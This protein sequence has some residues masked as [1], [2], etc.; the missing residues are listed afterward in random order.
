M[1]ENAANGVTTLSKKQLEEIGSPK[2]K[3]WA[4]QWYQMTEKQQEAAVSLGWNP[5]KWDANRWPLPKK[6]RWTDLSVK[7]QDGLRALGEAEESWN[8]W[9]LGDPTEVSRPTEIPSLVK[10][11]CDLRFWHQLSEAEHV[12]AKALGF[13]PGAWNSTEMADLDDSINRF[14]GANFEGCITQGCDDDS[15]DKALKLA[16]SHPKVYVSFGCHPKQ[17][18][19]YDDKVE[20]KILDCIK[21]A[22]PKLLAFGECG[23]DYSHVFFGKLSSNRRVQ[24]QAFIRQIKVALA[25]KLPLVVHTR[26]ADRDTLRIMRKWIPKDYKLHLHCFHGTLSFMEQ[27][28]KDWDN[29][30]IGFSGVITV[31]DPEAVALLRK[32]PIERMLLE[33]DAPYLPLA[34][35]FYCHCG[36]IPVIGAKVAE[37]LNLPLAE[38][39]TKTRANAKFIY[40]I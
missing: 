27:C 20:A 37:I 21:A 7:I 16:L 38:V 40:G 5:M 10:A 26:G 8:T 31:H 29:V 14:F 1:V 11:S 4:L 6:T 35:V 12:A 34:S 33:T 25:M 24:R 22:G 2:C 23:L 28:L 17:A 19:F 3:V 13:S 9:Q 32:C 39:M 18:P 36:H 15:F 30:Y